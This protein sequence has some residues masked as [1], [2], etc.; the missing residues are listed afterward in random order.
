MNQSD[1]LTL[2]SAQIAQML[3]G[4]LVTVFPVNGTRRW[5]MLEAKDQGNYVDVIIAKHIEVYRLF[6]D[7]GLNTLL[8]P[9]FGPDLLTRGQ[10]YIQM[11]VAGLERIATDPMF[12]EFYS[13]YDVRV[14]F[15]GDYRKHL[16]A[17]LCGALDDITQR[18]IKHTTNRLF[19]GLFANEASETIAELAVHYY[20]Q[21]HRAPSR[22]ELIELYYG[23]PV[24]DVN[25]FIG[26][27]KFS[28]FDMPLLATGQEDLY[29]TVSPSLYLT[30]HGLKSILY[31]HLF[32]RPVGEPEYEKMSEERR[33]SLRLFYQN[34]QDHI[35]GVGEM[36]DEVWHPLLI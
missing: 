17:S 3:F 12:L 20:L 15:Y 27:D 1:F 35:Q 2:P 14:R 23:E 8:T 29:F 36:R 9:A 24:N 21:H 16:E 11:A 28:A 34:H 25:I 4:K 31:D 5:F 18:T 32:A 19:F 26:F 33:Q 22:R 7:H 30:Q 6:F 13:A 10:D